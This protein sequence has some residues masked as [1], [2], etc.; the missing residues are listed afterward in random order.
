MNNMGN[1]KNMSNKENA[2]IG[3]DCATVNDRECCG[4]NSH[5]HSPSFTHC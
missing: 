2:K 3:G 1:M 5:P 4:L